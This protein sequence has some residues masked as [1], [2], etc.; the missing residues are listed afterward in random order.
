MNL[1]QRHSLSKEDAI[2]RVKSLSEQLYQA[3]KKDINSFNQQ[4]KANKAD[5]LITIM[6]MQFKGQVEVTSHDVCV[7]ITLPFAALLFKKKI[8]IEIIKHLKN[9]L[10]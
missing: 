9:S 4:W 2:N 6:R 8:E 1:T 7:K 10:S 5:V 3:N